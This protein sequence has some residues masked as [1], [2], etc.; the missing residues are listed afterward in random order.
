MITLGFVSFLTNLKGEGPGERWGV[1]T[2]P[3]PGH[4][5]LPQLG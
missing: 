4:C 5:G 2:V 3:F 1:E